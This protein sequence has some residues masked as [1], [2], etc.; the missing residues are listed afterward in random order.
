MWGNPENLNSN[1]ES[2]ENNIDK[3]NENIEKNKVIDQ[4]FE[5]LS[6]T[7]NELHITNIRSNLIKKYSLN[8]IRD[9]ETKTLYA[10]NY[11][12]AYYL[13]WIKKFEFQNFWEEKFNK[14][15]INSLWEDIEITY[16]YINLKN[17]HP[18][19]EIDPSMKWS[20]YEYSWM[21]STGFIS[22]D[23]YLSIWLGSSSSS[24]GGRGG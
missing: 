24:G 14:L 17:W 19:K 22:K 8:E 23:W 6:I 16:R 5:Y 20:I 10:F 12:K 1:Q 11:L 3:Q 13:I 9:L 18:N 7:W 15:Y 21:K 2:W 4:I